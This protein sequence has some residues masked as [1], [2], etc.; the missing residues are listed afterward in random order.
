MI[1]VYN[2]VQGLVRGKHGRPSPE[3]VLQKLG[4]PSSLVIS[5]PVCGLQM[6]ILLAVPSYRRCEGRQ[7][8]KRIGKCQHN[9]YSS[10]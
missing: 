7:E 9:S 3:P 6:I 5:C 8:R 1:S 10:R 2:G 4:Q